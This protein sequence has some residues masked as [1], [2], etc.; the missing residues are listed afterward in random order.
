M[1]PSR[2]VTAAVHVTINDQISR[3]SHYLETEAPHVVDEQ[4]HL[5]TGT[6]ERA[7]WHYGYMIALRDIQKMLN[8]EA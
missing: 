7:Y 5:D 2:F 3:L 1:T 6:E 8:Q 4:R